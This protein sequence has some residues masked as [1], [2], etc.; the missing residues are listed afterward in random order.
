MVSWFAGLFYIVR[1]MIYHTEADLKPENEKNILQTQFKIMEKRLWN[2]ITI[3]AMWITVISGILM[4][5]LN[6][7]LMKQA[8]IHI[9]LT[10]IVGLLIY[11]LLT[12]RY[13][14]ELQKDIINKSSKF[15]RIWNE[16]ATLFLVCLAFIV[17][18]KD[19]ISWVYGLVG[20]V[21]FGL[22]VFSIVKLIKTI[23]R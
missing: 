15:F 23:S 18:L 9:K 8:W 12:W 5:Y 6:P 7:W 14:K 19:P 10:F 13:L 16:V 3:P 22:I 4:L 21:L 11:Q 20:L 2:I 17:I 1:L